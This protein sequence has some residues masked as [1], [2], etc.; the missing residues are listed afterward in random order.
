MKLLFTCVVVCLVYGR[1]YSDELLNPY[2]NDEEYSLFVEQVSDA[3]SAHPE[4]LSSLDS[5]KAAGANLKGSRSNL[6]PQVRLIIDSNNQLDKSFEDGSNNLFEKSR[7]EHKTDATITVSQ[8]LYDFG[9]TRNDISKSEALFDAKRAELSSTILDLIYRSVISYIN[10]SAYTI[11]TNTINDSYN[12][13]TAIKNRIEQKV[14]GGLSAPREL[15]RAEARQAE[16][17]A[18]LITVR[19]NLGKAISEYRVYF[20][21]SELPNK[22]PPENLNLQFR[23]IIESRNLMM[24]GNPNIL[25][26][27]SAL[28]ASVFN[29]KKVKG[30]SLPRLDLEIRGSQY[31]LSKQSDEYDVYSGL[32]LSY[33]LYTGGRSR[34]LNEEAQA[35]SSAY[36]NNKDAII[37][38]I[39]AE[40]N[41]SLQII[42]LIPDNIAAY[43]NAYRANKQS[44][45]YANE[46]FQTSN[47]LL[48]DLLQTER[49]FLESS[50]ALIEA[51]RSSQIES[52]SYM[53]LTGELGD[54]FKLRVD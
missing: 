8:L 29:T 7:S 28:E 25:R 11:F 1:I 50:Q 4:Y 5:L 16:A 19:Q 3:V 42:K 54:K 38:K 12:R 48:L 43:Q 15:S 6:L 17:Y 53:K 39:E 47:V 27:I 21:S 33:D 52:Y 51:L 22:L 46:Q 35:E 18:K 37:R 45:Y 26:A 2:M 36:M 44:Q 24:Q 30:E 34:A 40:M 13:H 49:D 32:N 20:P 23:S 31:N 9:A 41:N 10:V 14:E